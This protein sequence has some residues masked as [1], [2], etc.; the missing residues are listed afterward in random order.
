MN[1]PGSMARRAFKW[2]ALAVLLGAC[3]TCT[4][5]A[6]VI[7]DFDYTNNAAARQAWVAASAPPVSVADSGE[8]GS[9]RVMSLPCDF[10]TRPSRCYWDKTSALDLGEFTEFALEVYAPDPS[11]VSYF[12]LYFRSGS[13]WYAGSAAIGR[14]GWQTLR[15]NRADFIVEGSP[16]GWHQVNGIRLS[17]WKAAARDTFLAVRELRAQTP[18]VLLVKDSASGNPSIVEETIAR[19]RDWL[20]RY[21]IDCGVVTGGDVEAGLLSQARLAILP[22]NENISDAQWTALEGFVAA[23]GKLMVYYLLPAR[24]EALLGVSRTGWAQGD[25]AAW[26]FAD[27]AVAGLPEQVLQASWNIT[28]AVPNGTLNSRVSATWENSA[29]ADTG[30]AAWI[31]S[32]HGYFM[33]HVLLGDDAETKSYALLCL[34]GHFLPEVWTA[35]ASGAIDSIGWVGPYRDYE[36]AQAGI[37]QDAGGTLRSGR[38]ETEL[39]AAAAA[40]QSA[41]A[42][43]ASEHYPESVAAAHAARGHMRE[44]YYLCLRPVT[45]EFRAI[46][47]HHAT[48]PYPGN[49][50]A[51]ASA[52]ASN[53]FTAVFPNML[54]GG[55]AHYDSAVLP[56]SAEYAAHG[57]QVAACV[58]AAHA[59]GLQVHVWKVNWNLS[60][61]PQSFIDTL[62]AANR[63]QVSSGGQPADWLCPSHPDNFALETNSMLE[64]VRNY[65]VDGIHSDYIR[66]PDGDHCYCSGCGARFQAQTGL[67]VTNWPGQVL[68]AGALRNAFLDWRRE[69]IT[70]LVSAVY[71][72]AKAI[73]PGVKVS[74]AVFPDAASAYDGVGQ[75]WRRWVRD[76]LLDFVCPMD[77]TGSLDQFGSLVS[78]QMADVQGRMPVY[79]GIGAFILEPDGVLAQV[80]ATRASNTGGFILFE[81]SASSAASLFPPLRAGA[82]ADDDPDED[83]DGLPDAW[84]LDWFDALTNAGAITDWDQDGSP[85]NLEFVAGMNPVMPEEPLLSARLDGGTVRVSFLAR[86]AAGPGYRNA[87]RHYRLE[88]RPDLADGAWEGVDGFLDRVAVLGSQPVECP[89]P[90][91]PGQGAYFRLRIWLA[92]KL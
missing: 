34:V 43:L 30:R 74:A 14:S 6:L 28:Y 87:Q 40:R 76:G 81:L 9:E 51:A 37:R 69:Q 16:A 52:L 67:A 10:S 70:R 15:F 91:T 58:Q 19:H 57:D 8:W 26:R 60:G 27:T 61:A 21:G 62:R 92:E 88:R 7:D 44:A 73:R 78:R 13:G 4:G 56:H 80:Q 50:A 22:Y 42:A 36:E 54:W 39:A 59:H 89:I 55:L 45:P 2:L 25:W 64:V 82:M 24:M 41:L 68:A 75:D 66:Y 79:P 49:W 85:D 83:R 63:T 3:T 11:A 48:G 77:Y 47:E 31:R 72:G 46:W 71:A 86:E 33:S 5:A 1:N 65:A 29:G 84:E 90:V 12:T 18:D 32:D 20:G 23:G 53:G 38:A 17:P 35:A